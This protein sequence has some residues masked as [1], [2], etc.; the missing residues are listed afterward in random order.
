MPF[1]N[2]LQHQYYSG[3]KRTVAPVYE[4]FSFQVSKVGNK[5]N[6]L[7]IIITILTIVSLFLNEKSSIRFVFPHLISCINCW[8]K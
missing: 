3:K 4:R 5:S 6:F 2:G 8:L 7:L 1:N